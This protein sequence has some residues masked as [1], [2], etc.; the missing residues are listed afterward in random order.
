MK[1]Q[2]IVDLV[3]EWCCR[4]KLQLSVRKTNAIF[5]KCDWD[6]KTPVGRRGGTRPDRQRRQDEKS[7][8]RNRPSFIEIERNTIASKET[9]R[10]LGVHIRR[11]LRV[12][13]HIQNRWC[14]LHV[15]FSKLKKV[16]RAT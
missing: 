3:T 14:K 6:R 16:A 8:L 2:G 5:L 13:S 10:Y 15:L 12:S 11:G 7:N 1:G 4:A 9:V